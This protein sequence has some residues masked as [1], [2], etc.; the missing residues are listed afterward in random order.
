MCTLIITFSLA[1]FARS[2]VSDIS[3]NE[4][5]EDITVAPGQSQTTIHFHLLAMGRMMPEWHPMF[6][7]ESQLIAA[8]RI[9]RR[10]KTL[11]NLR[12]ER[13]LKQR[14]LELKLVKKEP[15]RGRR[16]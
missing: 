12:E 7:T 4:T 11:A 2:C 10:A 14:E 15:K 13:L 1:D 16:R 8:N 3:M 9:P 6:V 5:I